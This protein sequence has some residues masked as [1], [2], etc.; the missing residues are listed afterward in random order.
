MVESEKMKLMSIKNEDLVSD[1]RRAEYLGR[2]TRWDA[3][4]YSVD[5]GSSPNLMSEICR[6][7]QLSYSAV[8]VALD[9]GR[10]SEGDLNGTYRQLVV[11]DRERC[12]IAGGYRYAVGCEVPAE[13]LSLSRYYH[14]SERFKT[15]YLPRAVE[16]G[17]SFVAPAYQCGVNRLTMY[18]LD[19]LWE[20]IARVV[21]SLQAE[22]LCGRVTLYDEL[23][24]RARNLL[25]GYMQYGS[26]LS[27][28]LMMAKRPF[29]AGISRRRYGEIFVGATHEE[30][31]KILLLKMRSMR[32][33]IPPIISSYLRLSPSLRLFG[34]YRNED[35]GGVVES[36][37]MLTIADF[38][39]DIKR[40]YLLKE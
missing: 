20:G 26:A 1:L 15:E 3:D 34:S 29:K 10:G 39:D 8:G 17:R 38:Y 12:E 33:R 16:L 7:R 2:A 6:V 14:L 5:G 30:N 37:I 27:E 25:V 31:Y 35:L 24:V 11:W 28:P 13:R 22:Y 4:I 21:K 18:A 36:A 19:A 40:R 23:G 9:D 32:R